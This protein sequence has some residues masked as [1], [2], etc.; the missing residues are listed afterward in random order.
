MYFTT[1]GRISL[2]TVVVLVALGRVL[3]VARPAP[4]R[5]IAVVLVLALG[6]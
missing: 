2:L 4:P 5:R 1:V 6:A 3:I